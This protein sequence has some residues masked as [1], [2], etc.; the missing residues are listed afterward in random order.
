MGSEIMQE[1]FFFFLFFWKIKYIALL[2]VKEKSEGNTPFWSYLGIL[3]LYYIS[4]D[5]LPVVLV[6][7]VI[8]CMGFVFHLD[9]P[10]AGSVG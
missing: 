3:N 7:L 5:S 10:F 1:C 6:N 2:F 4:Y 9:W 8:S